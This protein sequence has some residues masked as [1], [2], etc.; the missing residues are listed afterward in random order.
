MNT[1]GTRARQSRW[2]LYGVSDGGFE[3]GGARNLFRFTLR[4]VLIKSPRS[5]C[6]ELSLRSVF[7]PLFSLLAPVQLHRYGPGELV[8]DAGWREM[9]NETCWI[10]S[11]RTRSSTSIIRP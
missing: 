4:T 10:P 8:G 2:K 6:G 11:W 3:G 1:N 7:M 5:Q 9:A